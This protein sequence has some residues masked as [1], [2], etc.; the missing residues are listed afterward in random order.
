SMSFKNIDFQLWTNEEWENSYIRKTFYETK[1]LFVIFEFK[2]K[3]KDNPNR[4]PYFKGIKLWNMPVTTIENEIKQLWEEVNRLIAT[5]VQIEYKPYGKKLR[6]YNNFP[7]K[8]FNGVTHIRPKGQ[9]GEDKVTLPN[10]QVITKQCYW[11]NDT[12]I[13]SLLKDLN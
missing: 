4:E 1:F 7:K 12:Y 9:N 6:E 2:E 3:K 5:G 11:L 13:A 10:G 8:N